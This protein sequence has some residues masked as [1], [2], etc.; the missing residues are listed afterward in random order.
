MAERSKVRSTYTLY[1]TL[2]GSAAVVAVT[3]SVV[4]FLIQTVKGVAARD[5]WPGL[6]S[7]GTLAAVIVAL[8]VAAVDRSRR[9]REEE[10]RALLGA[11]A[12]TPRLGTLCRRLRNVEETFLAASVTDIGV[13]DYTRAMKYAQEISFNLDLEQ[14]A[15]LTPLPGYCAHKLAAAQGCI[16]ALKEVIESNQP[17]LVLEGQGEE[18]IKVAADI[19]TVASQAARFVDEA[20]DI[21]DRVRP[22]EA[23]PSAAPNAP[24]GVIAVA[25]EEGT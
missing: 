7:L 5:I 1:E 16:Q 23:R 22:D 18:R 6:S 4:V 15:A 20:R 10:K 17:L 3:I 24:V 14:L 12:I 13:A 21:M 2:L 19:R 8:G 9:R 11:C 25:P